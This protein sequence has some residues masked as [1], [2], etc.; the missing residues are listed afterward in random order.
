MSSNYTGNPTATQTPG[1]APGS[2]VLPILV[3]PSDG[4]ADNA[5]SV[6]QAFRECADFIGWL[7][8][9]S[10]GSAFGD[11]SDGNV[12][13]DGT[14]T[15]L[16]LVPVSGV[17]T[18]TRDIFAHNLNVTGAGTVLFT[19]NFR[20]FCTGTLTT[21]AGGQVSND[22]PAA[23]GQVAGTATAAGTLF[24]GSSGGIG[25][26]ASSG[27]GVNGTGLTNALGG[28]GGNA[29]ST[30]GGTVAAPVATL[31]SPRA[32]S[33]STS[34]Y[35]IGNNSGS[36]GIVALR[37]GTGGGGGNG[38]TGTGGGGGAGGGTMV[39]GAHVLAL[40]S[41]GDIHCAGGH[42]GISPPVNNANGGGG[43]G[44]GLMILAYGYKG[45][46]V[47]SAATNCNFGSGGSGGNSG[48]SGGS[49]GAVI[50]LSMSAI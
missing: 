10:L 41:A 26:A 6:A 31:G 42:G 33:V 40:A 16:G 11:G 49:V 7:T 2:G 24:G 4:D 48:G 15:I 43:G 44:G 46:L 35:L 28:A 27:A 32:F 18:M 23:S 12:V 39:I 17:Y 50:E 36:A 22:G 25:G 21:A 1:S 20:V 8:T 13:F 45:G 37:A 38:V 19:A 30:T 29:V 34:G 14:T 47:F 3:L 9:Q 5:A